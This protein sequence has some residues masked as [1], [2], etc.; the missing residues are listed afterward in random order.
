MKARTPWPLWPIHLLWCGSLALVILAALLWSLHMRIDSAVILT[1]RFAPAETARLV[2]HPQGGRITAILVTEGMQIAAGTPL[3]RLDDSAL[4]IEA[5]LVA[6]ERHLLAL[7]H[8]RLMAELNGQTPDFGPHAAHDPAE[9]LELALFAARQ[10]D[11]SLARTESAS[12]ARG[13]AAQI[14]ALQLQQ[15]A[16]ARQI[17]LRQDELVAQQALLD[18]GLAQRAALRQAAAALAALQADDAALS[19]TLAAARQAAASNTHEAALAESRLQ[20]EI[21]VELQNI[22]A[23][24][25]R[26][27]T[28][29][30]RLQAEMAGLV[31]TAPVAGLV[32]GLRPDLATLGAG[33]AALHLVPM[34]DLRKVLADLP[35]A[36]ID[37]VAEG[38]AARLRFTA[39]ALRDTPPLT[40]QVTHIAAQPQRDP[41]SGAQMFRIEVTLDSPPPL[42][43]AGQE[44]ELALLTGSAP[45]IVYLL[46]P[47]TDYFA[48]ALRES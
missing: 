16:L 46:A 45:P 21:V 34:G 18:A 25:A 11:Q 30:A 20:Q 7:R 19:A 4:R 37:L 15:A 40:G 32:Q 31:L 9:A 22:A 44:A 26:L 10:S 13:L 38:Q 5:D 1:A 48:K 17:A 24:D 43:R 6:T 41:L 2:Q 36:T 42:A 35:A 12:R 8:M 28:R 33:E 47:L 29:A 14:A 39:Q 27:A 3:L 23:Q